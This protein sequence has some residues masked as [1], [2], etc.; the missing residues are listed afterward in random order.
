[1]A[2]QTYESLKKKFDSYESWKYCITELCEVPL[3][4]DYIENRI[5]A[6]NDPNNDHTKK[7]VDAWG[8]PHLQ[9]V[10]TWFEKAAQEVK[11]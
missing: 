6:L 11:H 2:E 1:M 9:K 3:T 8:E 10:I 7:F 4:A 5:S